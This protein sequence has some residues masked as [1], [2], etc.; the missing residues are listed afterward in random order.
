MS[1][2]H[3]P[4]GITVRP[5]RGTY[6][7]RVTY[8]GKRTTIG[9]FHTLGRAE[10]ALR[11]AHKEIELGI[12]TPPAEVR[13][14]QREEEARKAYAGINV[15]GMSVAQWANIWLGERERLGRT[16]STLADYAS[17]LRVHI[18]PALGAKKIQ[19]VTRND[20]DTF[21]ARL[22][23]RRGRDQNTLIVLRA[24]FNAAVEAEVIP[25]SPVKVRLPSFKKGSHSASDIATVAE[26]RQL[27]ELMP[28]KLKLAVPLAAWCALRQGEILGLQRADFDLEAGTVTVSR[29]WQAKGGQDTGGKP[30][31]A[32]PKSAAGMRTITFPQALGGMIRKHLDTYVAPDPSSPVFPGL[33]LRRPI[34]QSAFDRHWR[35]A[36]DQVRPGFRFHNLRHTG[37]TLYA[38]QGAT[39]EEL[40]VR[41]GHSDYSTVARYQHATLERDRA[42]TAKLDELIE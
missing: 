15:E 32:P 26:V 1:R 42:L 39:L 12:F 21:V 24:L 6:R 33:D 22:N 13:K 8:E 23:L 37:L 10:Q 20:I 16:S 34:A 35:Q 5:D 18:L 36:R 41:A 28:N 30:G 7:V 29:Q 27:T 38:Q 25:A 4:S 19:D 11:Q 14:K 17:K 3:L 31:Y 9:T 40:R 2:A